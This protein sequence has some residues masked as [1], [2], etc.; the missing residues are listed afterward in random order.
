MAAS[1]L[2]AEIEVRNG[3]LAIKQVKGFNDEVE[4]AGKAGSRSAS[5]MA[6]N[7]KAVRKTESAYS[8]LNK[9]TESWFGIS[10]KS[11]VGIATAYEVLY[12]GIK[13]AAAVQEKLV[14]I[15][16]QAHAKHGETL[17]FQKE[18]LKIS[19]ETA[20]SQMTL[21]EA[22]YRARSSGV[23][24]HIV[25]ELVRAGAMLGTIGKAS[26]VE[27]TQILTQLHRAGYNGNP[28]KVA[29]QVSAFVGA[30]D[31]TTEEA[32]QAL[33]GGVPTLAHERGV[34]FSSL[35]GFMADLQ[36]VGIK[37]K[38]AQTYTR[39]MLISSTAPTKAHQALL[40]SI[41][42]APTSL[43]EALSHGGLASESELL[44]KAMQAR[45]MNKPA[46]ATFMGEL[47]GV[48]QGVAQQ[49]GINNIAQ[50]RQK[51]KQIE[52]SGV[53][54]FHQEFGKAIATPAQQ[55]KKLTTELKNFR[56]ELGQKLLPI[57]Q[58]VFPL[59]SRGIGVALSLVKKFLP[60]IV[61]VVAVMVAWKLVTGSVRVAQD[62]LRDG[63]KLFRL[64]LM[65]ETDAS[66]LAGVTEDARAVALTEAAAATDAA[67]EATYAFNTA[68]AAEL[69]IEAAIVIAIVEIVKHFGWFKQAG[70]NAFHW[71]LTAAQNVW[72]WIKG[73]WPYLLA[74]LGGPFTLA[75][76]WVIKHWHEV[77][78]FIETVPHKVASIF[79]GLAKIIAKPFEDAWHLIPNPIRK[80]LGF[81]AKWLS[82][83]GPVSAAKAV[84]GAF[85]LHFA[86]GG[87]VPGY[88]FGDSIPAMLTPGEF[89]LNR[90]AVATLGVG[91]LNGLNRSGGRGG[92]AQEY[93]PIV[94][95]NKMDSRV[96]SESTTRF[97]LKKKRGG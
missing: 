44:L 84:G 40:A 32:M 88:G 13:E 52:G 14:Q 60:E 91:T 7:E 66:R 19:N 28:Q 43:R 63:V 72:A 36:D 75:A 86:A 85:G 24:G 58:K 1:R 20:Q 29:S 82:P 39:Q 78:G 69:L 25:D 26:P 68:M 5:G 17:K 11:V 21:L 34:K 48:K 57:V 64:V 81:G 67:T 47:T 79:S 49:I 12:K 10:L 9:T 77:L 71:V 33:G 50:I 6:A 70:V 35:T 54:R 94:V 59:L 61:G 37:A 92:E 73:N 97:A 62:L 8:K 83:L 90:Q 74:A 38:Q 31:M 51:E 4:R 93:V 16:N 3:E 53:G 30:G 15:E 46:Q 56:Q 23:K 76:V 89:V 95:I 65:E 45:G 87:I 41:G 2:I 27:A 18:S 42:L 96:L 22:T 55:W 80:V